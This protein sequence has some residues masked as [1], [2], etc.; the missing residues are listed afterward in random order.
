MDFASVYLN[1]KV[2]SDGREFIQRVHAHQ[3]LIRV[4]KNHGQ[5]IPLGKDSKNECICRYISA[6]AV[7]C[8]ERAPQRM[9]IMNAVSLHGPYSSR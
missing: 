7:P 2:G 4:F 3:M 8:E 1:P 6:I 9:N 5:C